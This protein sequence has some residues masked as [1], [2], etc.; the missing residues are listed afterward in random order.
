MI[1]KKKCL[2][3]VQQKFGMSAVNEFTKKCYDLAF[4]YDGFFFDVLTGVL[5][6]FYFDD[7]GKRLG[8][9]EVLSDGSF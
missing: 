8:L 9:R 6:S 2:S 1:T 3:D 7:A 4:R 5:E